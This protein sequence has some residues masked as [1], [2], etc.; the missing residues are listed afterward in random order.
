[1]FEKAQVIKIIYHTQNS[2]KNCFVQL[3]KCD[4]QLKSLG[5]LVATEAADQ[6]VGSIPIKK[7]KLDSLSMERSREKNAAKKRKSDEKFLQNNEIKITEEVF[8]KLIN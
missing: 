6:D 3:K 2:I 7:L 5:L 1:M 4:D 8:L